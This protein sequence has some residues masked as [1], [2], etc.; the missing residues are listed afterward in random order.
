MR[1]RLKGINSR[2]KALADG[3]LVT[4]WY[5]WKGGPRLEGKPGSAEFIASYNAAVATKR[6]P[7][8]GVILSVLQGYQ[9][10]DEFRRQ[11]SERTRA[12]Y[13]RKIKLIEAEFGDFPLGALSDRRTRGEFM[14]WRDRLAQASPRQADYAWQVLALILSWAL[15]RGL[16]A[17]NPCARAAGST[18]APDATRFGRTL[19]R[20]RSTGR[21]RPI[22]ISPSL[23]P[24]GRGSGKATSSG[25]I[26]PPTTA[27][28]SA[29]GKA[30]AASAWSFRSERLL[31]PRW[32][33]R[34][35]SAP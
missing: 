13:I 18:P 30:R 31:E 3:R 11:L 28:P 32:T 23:S 17:A 16:I 21:R 15:E 1:V 14:A 9:A 24:C 6:R 10:T 22:C 5:A 20:R 34:S 29:C 33:R 25:F 7:S 12:D 4:Y 35:V 2:R 27:T 8:E 19:T 26:G